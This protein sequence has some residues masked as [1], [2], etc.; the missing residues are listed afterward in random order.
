MC[1]EVKPLTYP[2]AGGSEAKDAF[3]HAVYKFNK[4]KN[5]RADAAEPAGSGRRVERC[6]YRSKENES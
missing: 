1:N 4:S 2:A 6:R 5:P 3:R